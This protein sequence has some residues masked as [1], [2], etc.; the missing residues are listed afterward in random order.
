[1]SNKQLIDDLE[2]TKRIL[3]EEGWIKGK[4]Q[5]RC[6][7]CLAGA[8]CMATECDMSE[9]YAYWHIEHNKR[10]IACGKALLAQIRPYGYV[11]SSEPHQLRADL[12]T[13]WND[14]SLTELSAV[15]DVI[16]AAIMEARQQS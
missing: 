2:R 5:T 10:A 6:G 11:L 9:D 8:V 3:Q 16:D 12:I 4:M 7:V 15:Y 13:D 14:S 1:M